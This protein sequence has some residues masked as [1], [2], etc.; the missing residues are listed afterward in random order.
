MDPT[1]AQ[2]LLSLNSVADFAV[3]FRILAA[4]TGW[5]EAVPP[6][7]RPPRSQCNSAAWTSLKPRAYAKSRMDFALTVEKPT[8]LTPCVPRVW[9][10]QRTGLITQP[11]DA[12]EPYYHCHYFPNSHP[13]PGHLL[14]VPTDPASLG[15]HQ[16]Q[17]GR[18]LYW[19]YHCES[20]SHPMMCCCD[21][22]I[23]CCLF[24]YV[25]PVCLLSPSLF[26]LTCSSS[27]VLWL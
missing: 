10:E 24:S 21:S 22:R 15:T 27:L 18:Q 9:P 23:M 4:E 3:S 1:E 12:D 16:F 6:L 13:A 19:Q 14:L 11:G 17:C 7:P 5:D 25:S 26:S 8:M 2:R 20:G